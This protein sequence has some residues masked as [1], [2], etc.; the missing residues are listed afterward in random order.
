MWL[1][2]TEILNFSSHEVTFKS[3]GH[4]GDWRDGSVGKRAYRASMNISVLIPSRNKKVVQSLP[5][6]SQKSWEY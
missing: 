2:D 6:R 5:Q 3:G 4:L 1:S